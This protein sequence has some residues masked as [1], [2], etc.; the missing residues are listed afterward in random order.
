MITYK[1]ICAQKDILSPEEYKALRK[2][3]GLD[4]VVEAE[5]EIGEQCKIEGQLL[6]V[7][8]IEIEP[9]GGKIIHF[10]ESTPT[11]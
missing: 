4:N 9:D 2:S 10:Q 7:T 8:K 11:S 6:T 5:F 3:Y 1:E